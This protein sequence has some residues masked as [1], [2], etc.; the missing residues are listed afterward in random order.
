VQKT[1][2]VVDDERDIVDLIGYNLK[3]EGYAVLGALDGKGALEE[4]KHRPNLI[5]LDIMIPEPNGLEVLKEIKSNPDTAK[6]PVVFLTAKGT[7]IDEVLGLE[8]GADD[9]IIKPISIPKLIARIK[10]VL[11]RYEVQD[12]RYKH[13]AII[14]AGAIEINPSQHI[15]WIDGKEVFFPRKEFNILLY[16]C[17]RAG[18]LVN[19]ETLL[20]DVW[21]TEVRVVERTVD[22][23]IRKIRERL[24][25]HAVYIE[26]V[27]GV[28]YKIRVSQ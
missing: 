11:R 5:L 22:V 17:E 1:V 2:L 21:G 16:L 24:G 19:R 25:P 3:K 4:V 20:N 7:D 10:H 8:L 6:I 28:G 13:S 23:H 26:T 14:K 9:Y 15:V 18:H 27:K 12:Q